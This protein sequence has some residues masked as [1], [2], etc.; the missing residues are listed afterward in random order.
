MLY[1]LQ[2]NLEEANGILTEKAFGHKVMLF[3]TIG[4][5]LD[6]VKKYVKNQE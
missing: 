5:E 6:K 4:F 3:S 1:L 2:G